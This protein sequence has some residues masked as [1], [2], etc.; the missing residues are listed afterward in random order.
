MKSTGPRASAS[1]GSLA[2]LSWHRQVVRRVAGAA[3][4]WGLVAFLAGSALLACTSRA[5]VGE[6]VAAPEKKVAADPEGSAAAKRDELR[7]AALRAYEVEL[8]NGI[9]A[10]GGRPPSSE[11]ALGPDPW[12]LKR[13]PRPLVGRSAASERLPEGRARYVGSLRGRSAVV[14]LDDALNEIARAPAPRSTTG[15]AFLEGGLIAVGGELSHTISLFG[16]EHDT[17][18]KRREWTVD[19]EGVRDLAAG[20]NFDLAALDRRS[21]RVFWFRSSRDKGPT[22]TFETCESGAELTR[23]QGALLVTCVQDH[24]IEVIPMGKGGPEPFRKIVLRNDGPFFGVAASERDGKVT[25]AAGSVEDHPLDRRE[26]S[27]GFVDS[28]VQ[29]FRVDLATA[30]ASRTQSINVG[31]QGL[32]TPKALFLT[33]DRVRVAG[34]GSTGLLDFSLYDGRFLGRQEL[35][36]GARTLEADALEPAADL[37]APDPLLDAWIAIKSSSS[38]RVVAIPDA[39]ATEAPRTLSSR[40]G[41]ALIFTTLIAPFNKSEGRLSRFTCETCHFEGT[42]DGR[43]HAT[44]RGEVRATTKPIR[45]LYNN[46]PYFSRALDPDLATLAMNEFRA[47]NAKSDHE[48]LF[49]VAAAE[50]AGG[51]VG[52]GAPWLVH[53]GASPGQTFDDEWLRRAFMEFLADFTHRPNGRV[54]GRRAFSTEERRGAEL[55]GQRCESCHAAKLSADAASRVPFAEW[56]TSIFSSESPLV[57]GDARYELTGVVPTV[58]ER[59]ARVPSLR[60]V[61]AKRPYFTSGA[62]RDLNELLQAV[63]SKGT[64]F[65]HDNAPPDAGAALSSDERAALRAFLELL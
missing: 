20:P 40:V 44:G 29:L 15:V 56:E 45:G 25:V 58:H 55:F 32:V 48:P 14:L 63:R 8:R 2:L 38:P 52:V 26:G 59:G 31:E 62:A 64:Q 34:Y 21:A 36:P 1:L 11:T 13:L 4:K 5:P 28:F 7:L 30:T 35:P 60:R 47:A 18:V 17:L 27:F 23:T 12:T 9:D 54:L 19:G 65:F 57:F 53:L 10:N 42:T 6:P 22:A 43:T 37:V 16:V 50:G 46:R 39:D 61:Y 41:E 49:S 51:D 3:A 33:S 24:V